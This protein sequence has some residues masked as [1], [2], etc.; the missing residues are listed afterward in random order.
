VRKGLTRNIT[1][2]IS[3]TQKG[4]DYSNIKRKG[5]QHTTSGNRTID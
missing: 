4:G 3:G 5:T 2:K 1:I